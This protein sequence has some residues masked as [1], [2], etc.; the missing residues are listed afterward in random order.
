LGSGRH[1]LLICINQTGTASSSPKTLT[2]S[3]I[4]QCCWKLKA[5]GYALSTVVA[6]GKRLRHLAR[7]VPLEVPE[8]VKNFIASKHCSNG[9]KES[10]VEAYDLYV[11]FKGL[12]WDKPFYKRYDRQ[13]RIPHEHKLD[14]LIAEACPRMALILSMMK[15]LG[16][17]PVEL[18]WLR[19]RDVDLETGAVTIT[20]AK[21][22]A[23]RTLRLKPQ[24]LAMLKA[25]ISK[26]KLGLND[27]L[28]PVKP[29]SLSESFRRVRNRLALKLQD[30]SFKAIRLYD[31]R[32]WKATVTYHKTKDL[33]YVKA[34]LGHRDL[35]STLRY[36]Q[37]VDFENEEYTCKVAKNLH[38]AQAL[39]EQ[40]FEYVTEVEG[41]KL[42][43]KRK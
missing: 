30:A 5:E 22:G 9:F 26:R 1:E 38:E 10:L 35:R 13:P 3:P 2:A 15:D 34:M 31:F 43:R 19:V 12:R 6:V 41:F 33:F 28:F 36:V 27:R 29:E 23:G 39:I 7:H 37:L 40:G 16:V 42:F 21:Y 20:T 4:F 32:H 24:T 8:A 14:M 17:R 25:Y 18:T 11:K